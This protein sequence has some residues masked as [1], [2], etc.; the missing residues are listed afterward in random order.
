MT[1]E[2]G[3]SDS[4]GRVKRHFNWWKIAFFAALLAL[5]FA[6]EV[7]VVNIAAGAQPSPI[8]H[9]FSTDG[10]AVAQGR[11][12]RIDGDGELV[13]GTMTIEC[14]A[15]RQECIEASVNLLDKQVF[16][17]DISHHKA[18]FEKDAVTYQNDASDCAKYFTRIDFKLKKA[19]SVREKKNNPTN[20][21][22]R[23]LE[24][25]IEM[26]MSDGYQR[27]EQSLDEHFV[28]LLRLLA[29]IV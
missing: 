16:A 7:A 24:P 18:T 12:K 27:E 3:T 28:P 11:W 1:V 8:N 10:Y 13:P 26:Q 21:N 6:R 19:F 20:P 22:C 17:P 2:S 9:V 23:I 14:T 15:E 4:A 25:R 29:A 5:E